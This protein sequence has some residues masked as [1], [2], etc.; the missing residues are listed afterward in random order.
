ML[1][2]MSKTTQPFFQ[3]DKKITFYIFSLHKS[4]ALAM[5]MASFRI[6]SDKMKSQQHAS[7]YTVSWSF[8]RAHVIH[9]IT[10]LN[11]VNVTVN[12]TSSC[13]RLRN[14]GHVS[15]GSSG[16]HGIILR[17]FSK[18]VYFIS[19]I[20]LSLTSAFRSHFA[21]GRLH[22]SNKSF[23]SNSRNGCAFCQH[24]FS[25]CNLNLY[26]VWI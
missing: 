12:A 13:I 3:W 22:D 4:M 18:K 24:S 5:A 20:F 16:F 25:E 19:E 2:W 17:R 15:V 6:D 8:C 11:V 14:W 9:L 7:T 1:I 10:L 23:T 21:C 26:V